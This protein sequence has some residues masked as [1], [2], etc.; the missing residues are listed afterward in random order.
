MT[1]G[2][3]DGGLLLVLVTSVEGTRELDVDFVEL[4]VATGELLE[5]VGRPPRTV[6][7]GG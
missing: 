6:V 3:E 5:E 1:V 4:D 2:L 7:S